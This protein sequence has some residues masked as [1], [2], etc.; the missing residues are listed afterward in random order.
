MLWTVMPLE[1]VLEGSDSFVPKYNEITWKESTLV[2]EPL[3]MSTARVIRIIST[4]PQDFMN[5]QVQ[6]GNIIKIRDNQ[7]DLL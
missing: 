7:P 3:E 2:V 4:N 1:I 6:P 5:P